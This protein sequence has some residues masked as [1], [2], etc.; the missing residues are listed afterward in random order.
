MADG[1]RRTDASNTDPVRSQSIESG[2]ELAIHLD[3][4]SRRAALEDEVRQ[5]LSSSPRT[6]SPVW[7]YDEVGSRLFDE[8]TRLPEYYPT[9][10]EQQI[11]SDHADEIVAIAGADTLVELGSGTSEK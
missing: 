7:F 1:T 11:L 6:L 3:P 9:R 5:G 4:T 2:I 10:T 8:I